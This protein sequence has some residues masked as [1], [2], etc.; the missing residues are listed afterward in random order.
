MGLVGMG[1]WAAVRGN[2][3]GDGLRGGGVDKAVGGCRARSGQAGWAVS[4]VHGFQGGLWEV[5]W[6]GFAGC[7]A[8]RGVEALWVM[9][10]WARFNVHEAQV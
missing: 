1:F 7:V 9:G 6:A 8:C 4:W 3:C 10:L 5:M 2:A